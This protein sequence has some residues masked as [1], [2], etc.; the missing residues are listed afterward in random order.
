MRESNLIEPISNAEVF[1]TI[2]YLDP[3]V[4]ESKTRVCQ[5]PDLEGVIMLVLLLGGV[6]ACFVAL[7]LHVAY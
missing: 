4:Q 5:H 6:I 2:H 7:F 1:R 3:D